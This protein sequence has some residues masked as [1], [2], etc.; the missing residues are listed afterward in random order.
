[1]LTVRLES[2][3]ALSAGAERTVSIRPERLRVS[4]A[5]STNAAR[6]RVAE[7]T[8]LGSAV[9]FVL[10]TENGRRLTAL[11]S[12]PAVAAAAREGDT[13]HCGFDPA[14]AVLLDPP[15]DSSKG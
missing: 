12:D 14:D 2:P 10:E 13:V 4:P 7:K 6:A 11:S 8:F 3:P 5:P 15:D 1:V 9:R